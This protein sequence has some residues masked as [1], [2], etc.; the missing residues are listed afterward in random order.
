MLTQP[1]ELTRLRDRSRSRFE[2]LYVAH[3]AEALRVAYLLTGDRAL[4]EDLAQDAF[5]RVLGRFGDLRRGAFR[6]Y[7]LKTV[8]NL[9]KSHFRRRKTERAYLASNRPLGDQ[10]AIAGVDDEL[11]ARLLALP[12]R[13]RAA[14]VLRYCEDLS[15]QDTAGLLGTS[16]KAVRSLVG[17][18]LTTLREEHRS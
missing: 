14:V 16:P 18:A 4:A 5:V 2:E 13:Q 6:S 15:E 7:L 11:R 17:R 10:V 9:A 1:L 3:G 12:E 8:V